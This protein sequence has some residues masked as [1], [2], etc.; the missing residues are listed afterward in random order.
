M[1]AARASTSHA[2]ALEWFKRHLGPENALYDTSLNWSRRDFEWPWEAMD[3]TSRMTDALEQLRLPLRSVLGRARAALA[4]S[5][6]ESNDVGEALDALE[7]GA[8]ALAMAWAESGYY[9][10][11]PRLSP[12]QA[13]SD[14]GA[15]GRTYGVWHWV[16]SHTGRPATPQ[17]VAIAEIVLGFKGPC[18]VEGEFASRRDA[19]RRLMPANRALTSDAVVRNAEDLLTAAGNWP[20]LPRARYMPGR[21][22]PIE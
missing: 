19:A 9:R 11:G 21:R 22:R 6:A 10:S 20:G 1:S 17:E 12:G 13:R 5:G 7:R 15:R 18:R 3:A 8:T 2:K 4:A 16:G 14:V